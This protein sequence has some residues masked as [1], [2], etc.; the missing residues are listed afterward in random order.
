MKSARAVSVIST[1][2]SHF[3]LLFGCLIFL[4]SCS[5]SAP[6]YEPLDLMSHGVPLS[7]KAPAG[8][9]VEVSDLGI[10]KD[11]TIQDSTSYAVQLFETE[12][13]KLDP[14]G[15]IS[16]LKEEIR[17]GAFFSTFIQEDGTGFIFEKKVDENYVNYDFRYIQIRGDKQ[18]TFQAGLSRQYTLEQIKA[19]YAAVQ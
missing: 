14:V 8:V 10:M 9:T 7:I 2:K 16:E 17:E 1:M 18:Y 19:L 12:A 3:V 13:T 6:K 11:I 4:S 15:L 5:G